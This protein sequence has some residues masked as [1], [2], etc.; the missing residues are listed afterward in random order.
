VVKLAEEP[1][2]E[3]ALLGAL[4]LRPQLVPAVLA[5]VRAEDFRERANRELFE[6]I[7][8][9][10][11]RGTQPDVVAVSGEARRRGIS[12]LEVADLAR[13]VPLPDQAVSYARSVARAGAS[14]RI[15]AVLSN[16]L[17]ESTTA[18]PA[19]L[20]RGVSDALESELRPQARVVSAAEVMGEALDV[21]ERRGGTLDSI[22]TGF[23]D[24]DHAFAGLGRGNLVLMAARPGVGKSS[25]AANVASNVGGAGHAV[26]FASL[27][28]SRYEVAV[29]MICGEAGVSWER[30]R[31]DQADAFDWSALVAAAE[32]CSHLPLEVVDE[33]ALTLADVR[34]LARERRPALL[35]VDYLQLMSG[36]PRDRRTRQEEVAEVSRGLKALAKREGCAVLAVSQLNRSPE[37]RQD[38]RPQ[39][40]DLRDSG[41]LEQDA[42]VV[43]LLH[44]DGDRPGQAEAIVAKNRNGPTSVVP[45][46]FRLALTRFE[47]AAAAFD[48]GP[49]EG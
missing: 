14:R 42:D 47:D 44:R 9:L 18:D 21:L 2:A 11:A 13:E 39:L 49:K 20:V 7:A 43:L 36:G 4:M 24:L 27:E 31:R 25:L 46:T 5:A 19:E 34:S 32:R 29:R 48:A 33:G 40:S 15:A 41:A 38:R 30:I 16:A 1:E 28:M 37:H 17:G 45:L 3:R 12:P 6:V 23:R 22:P 26:L 10:D 8:G 35:V